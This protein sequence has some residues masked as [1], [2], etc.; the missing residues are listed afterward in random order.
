[1]TSS[2]VT[3][4]GLLVGVSRAVS[5]SSLRSTPPIPKYS[6]LFS[7]SFGS[8]IHHRPPPHGRPSFFVRRHLSSSRVCASPPA[9]SAAAKVSQEPLQ[10][11]EKIDPSPSVRAGTWPF[12]L[13]KAACTAPEN[14]NRWLA[15]PASFL[16]QGGIGSV[17][18]WS[19]WNEPLCKV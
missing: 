11:V 6:I 15:V 2:S 5:S 12:L 4:C 10:N 16:V 3:Q 8:S 14:F 7:R 19:L 9:A 13:S 1:M 17:Y 18:A